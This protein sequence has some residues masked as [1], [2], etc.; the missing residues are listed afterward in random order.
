MLLLGPESGLLHVRRV[1]GQ[2]L[3]TSVSFAQRTSCAC[4]TCTRSRSAFA[5]RRCCSRKHSNK[6]RVHD[7]R[8][9][10]RRGQTTASRQARTTRRSSCPMPSIFSTACCPWD[11]RQSPPLAHSTTRDPV[12]SSQAAA[13]SRLDSR[14]EKHGME[15]S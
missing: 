6:G 5:Q 3:L 8:A 13:T 2:G 12:A 15:R 9:E 7:V 10:Q 4:S 1:Q 14:E 11:P